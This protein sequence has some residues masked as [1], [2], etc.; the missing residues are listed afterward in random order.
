M[1]GKSILVTSN[2]NRMKENEPETQGKP[3]SRLILRG[4]KG[5]SLLALPSGCLPSSAQRWRNCFTRGSW[6]LLLQM[7]LRSSLEEENGAS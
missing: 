5:K 3:S 2:L 4:F 7:S 6:A 1:H